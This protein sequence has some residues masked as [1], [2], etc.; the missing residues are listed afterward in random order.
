MSSYTPKDNEVIMIRPRYDPETGEFKGLYETIGYLVVRGSPE[1]V[2][3]NYGYDREKSKIP[4]SYYRRR[5]PNSFSGTIFNRHKKMI[6]SGEA[7]GE[8][9]NTYFF[10]PSMTDRSED[11]TCL[12]FSR[13]HYSITT[14][15]LVW[16]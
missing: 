1:E 10:L 2:I 11:I 3:F 8:C 5:I 7:E 16:N 9:S 6:E 4:Y 15:C 13:R 12:N 14:K